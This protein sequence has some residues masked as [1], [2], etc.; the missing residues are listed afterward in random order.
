MA[1]TGNISRAF[2]VAPAPIFARIPCADGS[3]TAITFYKGAALSMASG[4]A[5]RLAGANTVFLGFCEENFVHTGAAGTKSV[6]VRLCGTVQLAIAG[7]L[8]VT[9]FGAAMY[10]TDDNTFKKTSTSALKIGNLVQFV[11][12]DQGIVHFYSDALLVA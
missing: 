2:G 6:T 12:T 11:S 5:Q 10:A 8:A 9:D 3:T 1:L 4:Y 7:T